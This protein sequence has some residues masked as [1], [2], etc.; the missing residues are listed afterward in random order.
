MTVTLTTRAPKELAQKIEEL[1]EKEHL[2]KSALMRRLLAEAVERK[3]R[4]DA[5]KIY[6]EGKASLW[7]AAKLAGISLWE[8]IDL[9]AKEDIA[10][11]YGAEELLEDLRP[12]RRK[13]RARG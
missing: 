11:D 6:K 7:K 12:L 10:L 4:E 1:A 3:S 5:L 2:D 13:L 9:V 8:M